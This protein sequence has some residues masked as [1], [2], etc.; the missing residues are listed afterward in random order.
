V[1]LNSACNKTILVV[2]FLWRCSD[3]SKKSK[4]KSKGKESKQNH[5][6]EEEAFP[7]LPIRQGF[8]VKIH[9]FVFF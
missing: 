2:Y 5:K 6:R 4:Q 9:S 3:E 1:G 7:L 8:V